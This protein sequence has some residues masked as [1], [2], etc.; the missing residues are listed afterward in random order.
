MA[1]GKETGTA[2]RRARAG[3]VRPL[4]CLLDFDLQYLSVCLLLFLAADDETCGTV[5]RRFGVPAALCV[6]AAAVVCLY[7]GAASALH[8]VGLGRRTEPPDLTLPPDY[9]A[10]LDTLT[11]GD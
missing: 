11:G 3:G 10:A 8:Y 2:G 7:G 6:F 4:H 1:H 5:R 9:G